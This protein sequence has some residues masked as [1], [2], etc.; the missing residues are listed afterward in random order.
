MTKK[1]GKNATINDLASR[2]GVSVMTVSRYFNQPEK[3]SERTKK[4]ISIAI[5]RLN[6]HPNELARS[7]IM[8]KTFTIGVVVPD[9][10]N[11][12]FNTMYHEIDQ[13]VRPKRYKLLLCNTQEDE[14]EEIRA[15]HTLLSR[16][17]DGIIIA[18]VTTKAITLLQKQKTPFVLVDRDFEGMNAD[19]IGCDHYKGMCTATEHLIGLGHRDIAL[20][21]GPSHLYPFQ[22]R[23]RG[24]QDT[25]MQHGIEAVPGFIR[26]V[27]ITGVKNA[28]DACH[29]LLS[30]EHRPTAIIASNNNIGSGALKA[31]FESGLSVPEDIS[32]IVFDKINGYDVIRPQI[33]CI[34]QPLEFIGRNAAAFIL[35][36]IGNPGTS[37][38]RAV[39]MPELL[40]GNSCKRHPNAV[41][42]P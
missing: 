19:Y 16:A 10:R 20:L 7:L 31:I 14:E 18:P 42:Q 6:Y 8:K 26:H 28:R 29:Q 36:R 34:V 32:F 2:S 27:E 39:I 5:E 11:P 40:V 3:V 4:K 38:Q 17:V 23:I 37:T 33:T 9:I 15:L 12:F 24:Y 21:A 1:D 25:L 13:F 30:R 35:E 22:M 41:H